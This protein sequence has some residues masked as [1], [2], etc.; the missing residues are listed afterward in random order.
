M[1]ADPSTPLSDPI[2][3]FFLDNAQKLDNPF[4]DLAWLREHRPAHK[5]EA[6]G[7]WWVFPY[8]EVRTL[9]AD[10]RMSAD[11]IA[12]FAD[13]VPEGV[14][15]EVARVVPYLETWLIFLDGT[16]HSHMRS[17]I[18]RGFN[19][20]AI[21]ALRGPIKRAANAL[22]DRAIGGGRFDVAADYGYLL[23]VYVLA[24]FM[25]SIPRTTTRSSSGPRTSST[26]ST[27]SRSPTTAHTAC[28]T[29]RL[30]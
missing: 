27:S 30:R 26:S 24:D 22:L 25:E 1:T 19:V 20:R 4:A 15:D 6:S 8:D 12:G 16:A 10:K 23:P 13:G 5:H 2:S 7:Q 3:D 21:E 11:R 18:H 17:V 28:A 29:A 14:R 9:F